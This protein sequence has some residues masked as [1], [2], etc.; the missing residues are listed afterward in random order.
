MSGAECVRGSAEVGEQGR[1]QAC[2][3][4][5]ASC[6]ELGFFLSVVGSCGEVLGKGVT[7]LDLHV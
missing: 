6:K 3:G 2:R 5:S 4:R 7:S 1:G